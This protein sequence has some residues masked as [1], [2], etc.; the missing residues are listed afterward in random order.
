MAA[1]KDKAIDA[2]SE[3]LAAAQARVAALKQ[4]I[5]RAKGERKDNKTPDASVVNNPLYNP[6]R[7]HS[8]ASVRPEPLP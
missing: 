1:A 8:W 7:P 4:E 3:Q 5:A 6:P 2:L